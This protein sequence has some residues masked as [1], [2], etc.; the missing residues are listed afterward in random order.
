[1]LFIE[2]RKDIREAK[3]QEVEIENKSNRFNL[4]ENVREG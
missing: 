4:L 3:T 1:M 2:N